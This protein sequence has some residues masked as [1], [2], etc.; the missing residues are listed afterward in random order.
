MDGLN[1]NFKVFKLLGVDY[2]NEKPFFPRPSNKQERIYAI[3]DP[4][5]MLKL[6]RKY[7]CESYLRHKNDDLRWTYIELLAKRQSAENYDIT[8]KLT[9]FHIN[10]Q[11][12]PMS[13]RHA[14]ETL[15]SSV[16]DSLEQMLQDGYEEFKGCEKTAKFGRLQDSVFDVMNFCKNKK[17]DKCFKQPLCAET[18]EAI[19]KLFR[20]AKRFY[21]SMVGHIPIRSKKK[22]GKPK[23]KEYRRVP[24][25]S[26]NFV[27]FFGFWHNMTSILGLYKDLVENGPL[28]C[29]YTF[30]FSQDHIETFFSLMRSAQGANNNPTHQQFVAAYRS[31]LICSPHLSAEKTN[32]VIN[33]TEILKVSSGQK[34]AVSQNTSES[35]PKAL[36]IEMDYFAVIN[37]L[38]DPYSL[39]CF[40]LAATNVEKN[41][42]RNIRS[43][44]KSGC[45][46]CALVF[47]Q[48][49]KICDELIARKMIKTDDLFQPCLSTLNLVKITESIPNY[50]PSGDFVAFKDMAIT[51]FGLLD[52]DSL[53]ERSNFNHQTNLTQHQTISNGHGGMT[54]KDE[55]IYSIV[56]ELMHLK[57]K[58]IGNKIT[59]EER[60]EALIKRKKKKEK[61]LAGH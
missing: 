43:R 30:Q 19:E 60:E 11:L 48:N 13:V 45:K 8:H 32:C 28:D 27:G 6:V 33:S 59:A 53:Y 16:A 39:H 7:F 25:L 42:K 17:T 4:P 21:K 10:W 20:E 37:S 2:K 14:C 49:K 41:I 44:P 29:F 52:T 18:A 38:F 46:E 57:S 5:H 36:E 56:L 24:V 61:M 54:H 40:A 51:I 15:S 9:Q 12:N 55:F 31:L 35:I 47:D 1:A 58:K 26:M 3:S 50:T 23:E 22:G 34:S